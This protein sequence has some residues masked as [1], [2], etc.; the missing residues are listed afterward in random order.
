MEKI[1]LFCLFNCFVQIYGYSRCQGDFD[2]L[3]KTFTENKNLK[4][5]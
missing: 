1:L 3:K 2:T 4:T 5:L